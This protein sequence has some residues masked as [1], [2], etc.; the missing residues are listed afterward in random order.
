MDQFQPYKIIR[1]DGETL[2]FN[3]EIML[4]S[5]NT[6]LVSGEPN[7]TSVNYTDS[8]G[9]EMIHQKIEPGEQELDG[10]IL[11]VV[12][13]YWALF[14]KLKNFF[15]VN[16]TY[17]LIYRRKGGVLFAASNAW[18]STNLQI[19]PTPD[20]LYST[21]TIGLTFG[22]TKLTEYSEDSSG[23]E[24][25][26]NNIVL[27]L[28]SASS[29]GENWDEVGLLADDIGEVW[30]DGAGGIQEINVDSTD[31]IYPVWTVVGPCVNPS[32]QNNTTDSAATYNGAVAEGQTLTVDF[33]EGI[34]RL[35]TAIVSRYLDGIVSFAGGM[36]SVG[37]NS[38][39]GTTMTSTISW[40][41]IIG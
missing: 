11:P 30:I 31:V 32:L 33:R 3:N 16:Y 29:G 6:L 10:I 37:F 21:W 7:T 17:K 25:Y 38:D 4:S 39:G 12:S 13:S 9:G 36:N 41:N 5:D 26:A 1:S 40:N 18:I 35:D 27:T 24:I 23:V 8:D 22:D 20:E 2:E 34:A 19:P 15:R 14:T 28:I